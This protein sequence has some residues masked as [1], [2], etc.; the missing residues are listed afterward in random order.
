MDTGTPP[1]LPWGC[2]ELTPVRDAAVCSVN[3]RLHKAFS[4][5]SGWAEISNTSTA[6]FGIPVRICR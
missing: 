5:G 4:S 1:L 6:E 3:A 2:K